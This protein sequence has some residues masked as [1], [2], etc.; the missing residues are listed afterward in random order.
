MLTK[1]DAYSLVEAEFA[2]FDSDVD[3]VILKEATQEYSW[4]WVVF[5]QSRKYTETHD[6]QFALAGN[7][8]YIV[9]KHS[10]D[11]EITGTAQPVED[12]VREYEAKLE[13]Q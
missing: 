3:P 2:L 10:G 13:E 6:I 7:G 11:L 5:Y 1:D 9:N 4:G 8:P 12:Y